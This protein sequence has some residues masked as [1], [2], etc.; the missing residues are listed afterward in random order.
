MKVVNLSSY[1][2]KK[3][4]MNR[5]NMIVFL[6]KM[7]VYSRP[8]RTEIIPVKINLR[9]VADTKKRIFEKNR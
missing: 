4:T 7:T 5:S 9:K 1:N 3:V 2:R 6:K 8:P